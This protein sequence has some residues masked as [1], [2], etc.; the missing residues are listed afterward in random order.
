M[1]NPLIVHVSNTSML[2]E[3][4]SAELNSVSPLAQTLIDK[5]WPGP[6]TILFPKGPN[7]PDEVTCGQPTVAVRMPSHPVAQRLIELSKKPIAAP[8]ANLSGRPSPTEA[9]HVISDL[10]GRL[11]CIIDGGCCDIG[12]ESTVIDINRE[13]ASN[14]N[15]R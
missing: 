9:E 5:F 6:L 1:D 2:K 10:S 14:S 4:V 15:N 3:L 7:V 13:Y 8:S 11:Q 12:V